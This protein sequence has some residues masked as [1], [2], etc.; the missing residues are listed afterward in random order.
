MFEDF[1]NIDHVVTDI[2]SCQ[3]QQQPGGVRLTRPCGLGS[4]AGGGEGEDQEARSHSSGENLIH[5]R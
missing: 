2:T 5:Q 1:L 4:S 3:Q